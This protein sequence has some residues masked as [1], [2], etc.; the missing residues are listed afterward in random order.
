MSR[1]RIDVVKV[2]MVKE[3]TLWYLKRSIGEPKDAADIMRE[4]I[5]NADREHFILICLNSKNEP[6]HIETVSIGTI[7]FAVIHPRETFKTTILS[8][9][10]GII[11]GHNHPSGDVTP[12]PEDIKI[13]Q[14][15]KEISEMMGIIL[16][17]HITFS[18]N[19][20]HSIMD[21][22]LDD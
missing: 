8:N 14:R 5:G 11:I 13:T 16:Y 7:N 18:E 3:D 17:D 19:D 20:H 9:A 6:T 22:D 2:Q 15:I 21:N 4:F 10:T 12:S 1:K